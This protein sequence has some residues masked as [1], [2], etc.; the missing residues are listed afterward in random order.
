MQARLRLLVLIPVDVSASSS[1]LI[2]LLH[3]PKRLVPLLL[4]FYCQS[5][6]TALI[7]ALISFR[8]Y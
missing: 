5:L 3:S 1:F 6:E 4:W 2:G 8:F 7:G